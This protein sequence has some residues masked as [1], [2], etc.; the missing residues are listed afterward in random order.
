VNAYW[1]IS[2]F[3]FLFPLVG[4]LS[5]HQAGAQPFLKPA[6]TLHKPRLRSIVISTSVA[7]GAALAGLNELWYADYPRSSFHFIDDND[8]WLQVD[9]V[10]HTF[11][12][13][14]ES[15]AFYELLNWS[16]LQYEK[17]VWYGG[18]AGFILQTPIEILDGFSRKWGASTG[19]LAANVF[20]SALFIG[21]EKLW[22]E[23][24]F[25]L[26]YSFYPTR[27]ADLRPGLL[28]QNL[29]H[30]VIKDYNGQTYWL[31]MGLNEF[32]PGQDPLPAWLNAAV[33]YGG[34]GMT[35]G[36]SNPEPYQ[37]I[38]R[39]R[40]YYLSLDVNTT[41]IDTDSRLL[42]TLLHALN[43]IKFPSPAV[44][45]NGESGFKWHYLHF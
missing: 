14:Q 41:G 33:G 32:I 31:T 36:V 43:F 12:A 39:Y 20:G 17:N 18:L 11:T 19:D 15:R 8:A 21:Q 35:G 16:G 5:L 29:E 25:Q 7:Y 4:G 42:N 22:Q 34:Q 9:K 30:Q 26:K 6:D 23:Q 13:Y 38:T 10:G 2:K 28:G 1:L 24:K 45:Y 3:F 40:Q 37:H 44:E 27:Y